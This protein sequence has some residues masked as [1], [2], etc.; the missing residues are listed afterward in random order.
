MS[1]FEGWTSWLE[2]AYILR[3]PEDRN[4]ER[5][6]YMTRTD[7]DKPHYTPEQ[8]LAKYN[9]KGGFDIDFT[10]FRCVFNYH[11]SELDS[12]DFVDEPETTGDLLK[13][14]SQESLNE[15]N[16][17]NETKYEFLK[18][19]KANFH[20]AAGIMFLI[21]FEVKKD[22]YDYGTKLFQARVRHN[23]DILVEYIF[24]RPKPNQ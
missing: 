6:T 4:Y 19:V 1:E 12:D 2:P 5:P 23:K 13:K 14:L 3:K 11:P 21:T 22:S 20:Y 18:V 9:I 17:Q 24:C 10:L 16:Q 15:Y 7:Q 8:E